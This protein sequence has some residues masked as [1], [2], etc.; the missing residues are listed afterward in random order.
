MVPEAG[1]LYL[2]RKVVRRLRMTNRAATK[3]K[4]CN[5]EN[6]KFF[7]SNTE[8]CDGSIVLSS[9]LQNLLER[10]GQMDRNLSLY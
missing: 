6:N 9:P 7:D 1:V 2:E 8:V 5:T 10:R 4:S 3:N